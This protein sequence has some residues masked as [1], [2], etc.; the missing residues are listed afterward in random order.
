MYRFTIGSHLR[1]FRVVFVAFIVVGYLQHQGE[2]GIPCKL[3]FY[4][5]PV[6]EMAMDRVNGYILTRERMDAGSRHCLRYAGISDRGPFEVTIT[7]HRPLFFIRRDAVLPRKT[8]HCERR[9]VALTDF[10]GHPVDALYFKT[11]ALLFEARK[12]YDE[13]NIQTFEADVYSE[14]RYLME[15]FIHGSIEIH[16]QGRLRDGVLHFVDPKI[17]KGD[18]RPRFSVL[19]LDIET[20][21]RGQL[22]SI[23][24][25][26]TGRGR[27]DD[28][29]IGLVLMLDG[30]T[31]IP[32][33]PPGGPGWPGI[34]PGKTGEALP[35]G[36]FLYRFP[37][38]KELLQTF[39]R[40]L[41]TL[42]PDI[43]IGWHVIGFDL[44]FLER[45]CTRFGVPFSIGR[46]RR[47][48]RIREVRKGIY[49]VEASGR[50]VIDG[51]PALRGAFYNFDNF[52]LE[53]VASELLGTGKD[54]G[55]AT[56]K[57]AEIERRFREDKVALARYNLLDC[58]LVSDIFHKT[59]LIDH[60]FKRAIISGLA[61]DRVGMSVAAFD[62]FMLPRVHRHGLVAINVRDVKSEGH[63]RGGFVFA[64][65][66]GLY[67]HVVVLD[68]KSLY[69]SIIRTF[70][71]DPLS[72]LKADQDPVGTPVGIAFS[73]TEHVLPGYIR[74]LM[75]K[76]E[77]AKKDKDPHLSQ[78]IKILM[79]SFYGVMGTPGCRF[80]HPDLPSAITGTGQWVL[81][82][83]RRYLEENGYD[84]IYGDTDSVFV[85]LK[86]TEIADE[87]APGKLVSRLNAYI[88]HKI[89]D[90]FGLESQ[91]ELE[92]EK[93][94][95]RFFLPSLRGGGD[96]AKKRYAG[97]IVKDGKEEL[98][99]TGLEFVRS[100]WTR[101]ARDLQYEL[102][103]RIFHNEDVDDWLRQKV[104]DLKNHLYDKDL[105][106]RKRLTK[107][108]REYTKAIPPHVKAV[109][110][111]GT[112]GANAKE[113]RYVMTLRGPVPVEMP[114]D[115]F[116]YTHYI[117]KQLKPIF[118]SVMM[119][120]GKSYNEIIHG[121]Q[122]NLFS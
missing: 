50:I 68:F 103:Q 30:A 59:G 105:V 46:D 60:L 56:D 85:R 119:F 61:M 100:D 45:K 98:V 63:A 106:Y 65:E 70:N 19:S 109:L 82:T 22:Y 42:D 12:F 3:S 2:G 8:F 25:H 26:V 9:A 31:A 36:G 24:C 84:V 49:R 37:G 40:V 96:S 76:R 97:M 121:R 67:E 39:F 28:A 80:Y 75:E 120:F 114:H 69:P 43:L 34:L 27:G 87:K 77:Q 111:L 17:R 78:A 18:Y 21:Q 64:K 33:I 48:T 118:D 58:T 51:P 66:P 55:E 53:T 95:I 89:K 44:L 88:S 20:G 23:A 62:H 91:L 99:L 11:Q 6:I 113:S 38:E 4:P 35:D 92:F 93:H 71:I 16:G 29:G 54:I 101:F 10:H 107:P 104:N 110:L 117:E 73:R 13:L 5:G 47:A 81:K 79:N 112:A 116:D 86:A 90:D 1:V 57:V 14:E 122:L 102:F 108:P 94:F 72:R 41:R 15:R 7:D 32:D 115:D 83:T 74:S 52:R